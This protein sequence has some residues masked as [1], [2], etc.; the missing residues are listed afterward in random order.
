MHICLSIYIRNVLAPAKSQETHHAKIAVKYLTLYKFHRLKVINIYLFDF[1]L[2]FT[3]CGKQHP[4]FNSNVNNTM[5]NER[6]ALYF[7]KGHKNAYAYQACNKN[8]FHG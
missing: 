5:R 2:S 8:S 3:G 4:T 1:T 7:I 6:M